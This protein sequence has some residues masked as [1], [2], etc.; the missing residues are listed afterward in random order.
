MPRYNNIEIYIL[1]SSSDHYVI[2]GAS[3]TS[4]DISDRGSVVGTALL[5]ALAEQINF[6]VDRE[7]WR[8]NRTI[9]LISWASA[10]FGDVGMIEYLE[11]CYWIFL[12]PCLIQSIHLSQLIIHTCFTNYKIVDNYN[13]QEHEDVLRDRIVAYINLDQPVLGTYM[14]YIQADPVLSDIIYNVAK[15]VSA[16]AKYFIPFLFWKSEA[17]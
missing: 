3:R 2:I 17:R 8:P 1:I 4:F 11:V 10:E 16:V 12:F 15:R 13:L 9:K 14:P 6:L 7:A 5:L